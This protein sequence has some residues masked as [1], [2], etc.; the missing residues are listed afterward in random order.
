MYQGRNAFCP[1][2]V[3]IPFSSGW[4]WVWASLAQCWVKDADCIEVIN[5]GV[6]EIWPSIPS[7]FTLLFCLKSSP[8]CKAQQLLGL[9]DAVAQ[10]MHCTPLKDPLFYDGPGF[11]SVSYASASLVI[12]VQWS[13]IFRITLQEFE[14]PVV[15]QW[16]T[17]LTSIH[18]DMG[19]IPGL[20]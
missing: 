18:E 15:A 1:R 8:H 20:A 12:T 17:N 16:L 3:Y 19:L 7:R 13:Q 5:P 11:C 4:E 14:V 6:S 10:V 9:K 2:D